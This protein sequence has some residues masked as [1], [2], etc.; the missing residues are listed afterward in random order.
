MSLLQKAR[1]FLGRVYLNNADQMKI[2]RVYRFTYNRSDGSLRECKCV[3]LE[4]GETFLCWD[5]T[6][7]TWGAY[8]RFYPAKIH[9]VVDITNSCVVMN[10][11]F[12]DKEK[13]TEYYH[14]HGCH[15]FVND[16]IVVALNLEM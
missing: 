1:K 12:F 10:N 6:C 9:N 7:R 16:E 2:N 8:R 3:V 13:V 11:L 4:K 5:A 14:K 15:C